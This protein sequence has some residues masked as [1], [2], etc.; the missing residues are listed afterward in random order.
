MQPTD[1]IQTK[2][3]DTETDI[4][5]PPEDWLEPKRE[6]ANKKRL[7]PRPQIKI[8]EQSPLDPIKD[9]LLLFVKRHLDAYDSY[10]VK[11]TSKL[12]AG[13]E[14]RQFVDPTVDD[15]IVSITKCKVPGLTIE[16]YRAFKDRIVEHT[17]KLDKKLKMTRLADVHGHMVSHTHVKMPMMLTDRSVFNL[18]F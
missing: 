3:L 12:V 17:P 18:Y 2:A 5:M 7:I 16:K 10:E 15:S 1:R 9:K 6:K 13:M 14:V 4:E 8:V 11:Y